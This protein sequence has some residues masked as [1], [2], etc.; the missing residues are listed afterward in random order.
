MLEAR[1]TEDF[2]PLSVELYGGVSPSLRTAGRAAAGRHHPHRAV[3]RG[4]RRRGVPRAGRGGD[5]SLPRGGPRPRHARRDPLRRQRRDGLRRRA[6]DRAG[7]EGAAGPRAG[8]APPRGRHPPGHPGQRQPPADQGDGRRARG[9]RRDAGGS[10]RAGRDRLRRSHRV[11]AAPARQPGRHRAPDDRRRDLRR[12][13]RGARRRRLP[14]G[15]RVDDR[16]ARLPLRRDDQGRD[17]P[18]RPRRA[19]RAPRRRRVARPPLAGQVLVARPAAHRR[20]GGPRACSGRRG[21]SPDTC[22]TRRPTRTS[23]GQ[24]APKISAHSWRDTHED[25]IRRQRH[26]DG[27]GGV[28]HQPPGHGGQGDGPRGLVHGH[29]R[30]R[31]R[32]RR[33]AEHQGPHG[34]REDVPLPRAPHGRREEARRRAADP[35]VGVRRGDAA[36][37]P[38][39]RRRD[40]PVAQ[41]RRRRVRP[42]HRVERRARRQRP[43]QPGQRAV[44]GVLPALPRDRAPPHADLARRGR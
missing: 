38:G 16:H 28:H 32:A 22:T 35:D 29:R 11:P 5:R 21:S 6:A 24:P 14:R 39:R 12:G 15:Q 1:D 18:A 20:P 44:Q 37:R 33:L 13:P 43:D 8:A 7:D 26:R 34:P 25:R 2:L 19:A 3:R 41:Q 42:A 40:R 30:L 36:Q 4:A 10:G 31:L 9:L 23:R 17:L 27:E